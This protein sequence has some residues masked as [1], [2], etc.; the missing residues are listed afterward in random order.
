MRVGIEYGNDPAGN[1]RIPPATFAGISRSVKSEDPGEVEAKRIRS[2][3]FHM[4]NGGLVES[5]ARGTWTT[6]EA[7][8]NLRL[9][10]EPGF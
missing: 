9:S 3:I 2:A 8:A 4:K 1:P 5:P 6:T 10:G 7:G